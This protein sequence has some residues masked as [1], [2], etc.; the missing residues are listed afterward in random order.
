MY[1]IRII[2]KETKYVQLY[3]AGIITE[4][5][6]YQPHRV[7]TTT[8]KAEAIR[9]ASAFAAS[10]AMMGTYMPREIVFYDE[11]EQ[12]IEARLDNLFPRLSEANR[13]RCPDFGC[14][15]IEDWTYSDWACALAG[16]VGEM[17]NIVKK[18]TR[19]DYETEQQ[20]AEA[21]KAIGKELADIVIYAELV[22]QRF[23]LTL[24][25]EVV[26][27]FNE[28]SERIGSKVKL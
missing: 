12:T 4:T 28:V 1:I 22:A 13:K 19:G 25:N 15:E 16:E 2:Q 17:C 23:G 10:A 18:L 7:T 27:K 26:E 21:K 20:I 11:K 5:T 9:Y 24:G 8:K 14:G 6:P 3:V